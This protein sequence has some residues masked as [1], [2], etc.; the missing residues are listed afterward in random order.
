MRLFQHVIFPLIS[1][2][3]VPRQQS[4]PLSSFRP[5]QSPVE[6]GR[7]RRPQ[8][9]QQLYLHAEVHGAHAR[10]HGGGKD[11]PHQPVH[12]KQRRRDL[13]PADG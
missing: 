1:S 2:F 11:A 8:L 4:E 13:Q 9:T 3:S 10:G 6:H 7:R 12:V 5:V